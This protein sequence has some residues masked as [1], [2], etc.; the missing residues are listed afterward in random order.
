VAIVILSCASIAAAQGPASAASTSSGSGYTPKRLPDGQPDIQG[1]YGADQGFGEPDA[2]QGIGGSV[3]AYDRVWSADSASRKAEITEQAKV[4]KETGKPAPP[5]RGG[6][7]GQADKRLDTP[8]GKIP[9]TVEAR[10]K[11]LELIK[12]T[13]GNPKG[14][15][16]IDFVDTV[17][18]CLPAGVPRATHGVYNYN[19]LQILQPP[20][21]VVILT[22]WNH[23]YRIIPLDGRPHVSKNIKMWMG[24]SRGRWEGNTLVVD[25]TNSNGR[26]WMDQAGSF[27]TTDI[28]IVERYT[29]VDAHTIK[30][31]QT[32]EDPN[33]YTKPFKFSFTLENKNEPGYELYEYACTEGNLALEHALIKDPALK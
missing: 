19:G 14:I 15:R 22:E 3:P 29:I 6:G 25:W 26:T 33:V 11:K 31:E 2:F 4:E 23:I 27:H 24:D 17:M 1:Y 9:Y 21:H 32:I 30:V 13:V 18:R 16:H 20:G 10:A 28:H 8:D 7:G 5:P 12:E